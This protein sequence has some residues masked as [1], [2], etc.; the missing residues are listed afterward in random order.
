MGIE[1]ATTSSF[2]RLDANDRIVAV[3]GD[4]NEFALAND[5]EGL[6]AERV[7]GSAIFDHV[8]GDVSVMFL[9]TLLNGAR[10]LQRPTKRP[11]RCDSP[12]LKRFMEMVVE[13]DVHAEVTV[14]HRLL[15]TE[16]L[17]A[18][19]RFAVRQGA[20]PL[21]TRCSMCNRLK[22]GGQWQEPEVAWA[23]GLLA[24]ERTTPVIYGVCPDCLA[25]L[26]R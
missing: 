7:I 10:T 1:T 15:R 25:D 11:Y 21:A 18:M 9:R 13:P 3:G 4:W 16:S 22:V 5:A 6:L 26:R 2:Y 12:G 17:K 20:A 19:F 23:E 24:A 14:H 8:S